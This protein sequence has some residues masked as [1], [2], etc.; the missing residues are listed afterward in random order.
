MPDIV[1]HAPGV[2]L[3]LREEAYLADFGLGYTALKTLKADPEDWWWGTPLNTIEPPPPITSNAMSAGTAAHVAFLFGMEMYDEVYSVPPRPEDFP[4]YLNLQDQLK[5]ACR[6]RGLPVGGTKGELTDR[7]IQADPTV[8]IFDVLVRDWVALRKRAIAGQADRRIR[9][10]HRMA[11]RTDQ[12]MKLGEGEVVTLKEAFTGGLSEVSVFWDDENGIPM[13]ARFDKLK[14]NITLD[15]KTFDKWDKKNFKRSLLKEA[16]I[17][18]YVVQAVHYEAARHKLREF[19]AAGQIFGGT[20]E[21]RA[22]LQEIAAADEW[23]WGWVFALMSGAPRLKAIVPDKYGAQFQRA[24]QDRDEALANFMLYR[25]QFGLE[26]GVMWTDTE[27]VWEPE[28][29]DWPEF[30]SLPED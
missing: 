25:D 28:H 30:S 22:L 10:L 27:V 8:K 18:G 7:L 20:D 24:E 12:E 16:T 3:G 15:L 1:R 13:R 5:D 17:R 2:Y 19:V 29:D 23:A 4:D 6:V 14:P 21:E 9:L 11:M 26:P